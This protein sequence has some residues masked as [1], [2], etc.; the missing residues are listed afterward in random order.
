MRVSRVMH[1]YDADT[2]GELDRREFAALVAD[3]VGSGDGEG[4]RNAYEPPMIDAIFDALD[5]NGSDSIDVRELCRAL[6]IQ[7]TAAL[8]A[9]PGGS[10]ASGGATS[11]RAIGKRRSGRSQPPRADPVAFS[12]PPTVRYAI[13][14]PSVAPSAAA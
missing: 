11:A 9:V 10:S 12:P 4:G 8:D 13:H 5:L 1:A 3:L 6:R 2:N 7:P 14:A